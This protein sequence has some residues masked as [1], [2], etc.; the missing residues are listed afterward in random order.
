MSI[1][2]ASTGRGIYSLLGSARIRSSRGLRSVLACA[3]CLILA[4]AA[5]AAEEPAYFAK[6][7]NLSFTRD[8]DGVLE[9]RMH[10]HNGP[11]VFTGKAHREF[12]DA[13]YD[14]GRD[15]DNRVVI[16]TGTGPSWM[17][18]IDFNSLGDVTNPREWDKVYWEGKHVLKNLLDIEVPVISA[19][20]GPAL[21]HSEYILTSDIILAADNAVFQDMPHLNAGIVPGDGVQVLWQEV[22]GPARGRY[23]LWTQQKLTAS[24][25]HALGVVG[26]VLSADELMPRARALAHQLAK[27]PTLTLRYTRVAFTHRLKRLVEEG[28]GYGLALEGITATDI[29]NRKQ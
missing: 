26:E 27:Q 14:V 25:A 29:R 28:I 20:N 15:R 19:V 17:A 21:L 1:R 7:G 5:H 18:D 12:V 2:V 23:F 11:F 22:L 9:I 4:A 8:D 6:Y 13:F 10:T 24:E 16:L 3:G